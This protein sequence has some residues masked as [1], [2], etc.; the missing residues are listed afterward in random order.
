MLIDI[1]KVAISYI[2][3]RGGSDFAEHGVCPP[4]YAIDYTFI[5]VFSRCYPIELIDWYYNFSLDDVSLISGAN[6]MAYR[7]SM[8]FI[9][10]I[11]ATSKVYAP[12]AK[13][14]R[15]GRYKYDIDIIVYF[16]EHL[17][18]NLGETKLSMNIIIDCSGIT[19]NVLYAISQR[20]H[21]LKLY[22]VIV[23]LER[24]ILNYRSPQFCVEY[25]KF[26]NEIMKC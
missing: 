8:W 21:Q 19:D 4:K 3:Y 12:I 17:P 26:R 1:E 7:N 5:E 2:T 24:L 18:V 25:V 20:A 13:Y 14:L 11:F 22:D 16:I 9:D 10:K 23:H 6:K 15:V